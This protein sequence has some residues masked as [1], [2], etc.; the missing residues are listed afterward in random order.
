M[1]EKQS[2]HETLVTAA[3]IATQ[4]PLCPSKPVIV[5][6]GKGAFILRLKGHFLSFF[7]LSHAQN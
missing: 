5:L 6:S 4:L 3:A 1:R 7:T 2:R